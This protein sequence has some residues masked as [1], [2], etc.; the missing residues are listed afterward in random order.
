M[1]EALKRIWWFQPEHQRRPQSTGWHPCVMLMDVTGGYSFFPITTGFP[2]KENSLWIA[3]KKTKSPERKQKP[4]YGE[5]ERTKTSN[6]PSILKSHTWMSCTPGSQEVF[7]WDG[8]PTNGGL[9]LTDPQKGGWKQKMKQSIHFFKKRET[10][11]LQ[12]ILEKKVVGLEVNPRKYQGGRG[13]VKGIAHGGA[14]EPSQ[15]H[16]E[17]PTSY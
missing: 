4:R 2:S 9:H 10:R 11:F 13:A 3:K 14:K 8:Q 1:E 7:K 6:A 17:Q 5:L 12:E 15:S 16:Q